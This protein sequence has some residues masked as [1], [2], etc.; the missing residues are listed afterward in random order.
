MPKPAHILTVIIQ[1]G[2]HLIFFVVHHPV[3]FC[4]FGLS[5]QFL[6]PL[7]LI[8][9]KSNA[10]VSAGSRSRCER[11]RWLNEHSILFAIRDSS[12]VL[13]GIESSI[14]NSLSLQQKSSWFAFWFELFQKAFL[15]VRLP[16]SD[17]CWL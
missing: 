1:I 3:D 5:D 8:P 11:V 16:A 14:A 4:R 17:F 9:I 12:A 15:S 10:V 6:F 13:Q 7:S 2:N